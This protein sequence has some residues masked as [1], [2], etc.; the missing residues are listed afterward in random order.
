[1]TPSEWANCSIIWRGSIN[2]AWPT[3]RQLSYHFDILNIL[4]SLSKQLPP[5]SI[6]DSSS[7]WD[8]ELLLMHLLEWLHLVA[9]RDRFDCPVFQY[10]FSST[11]QR[12]NNVFLSQEISS[13]IISQI[14]GNEQNS[15]AQATSGS[16]FHGACAAGVA[17]RVQGSHRMHSWRGS[18]ESA[19][20]ARRDEGAEPTRHWHGAVH[21]A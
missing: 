12:R 5:I 19:W 4:V 6:L 13:S 2:C 21:G 15:C 9:L 16:P 18:D 3:L 10:Y 11:F 7:K 17:Q 8:W 1:V 14:S 20:V